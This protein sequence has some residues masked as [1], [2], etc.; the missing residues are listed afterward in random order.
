MSNPAF[1]HRLDRKF[2]FGDPKIGEKARGKIFLRKIR[3]TIEKSRFGRENPSK[4]KIIQP[5]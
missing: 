2:Q 1:P 4:S 3:V 5:L